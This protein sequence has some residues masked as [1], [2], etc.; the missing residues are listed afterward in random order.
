MCWLGYEFHILDNAFLV[1]RPGIKLWHEDK[2]RNELAKKATAKINSFI[3]PHMKILYGG[4]N[5]C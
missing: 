5:E 2:K 1:H 4:K 3:E